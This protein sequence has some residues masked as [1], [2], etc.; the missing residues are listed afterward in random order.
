MYALTQTHIF[1]DRLQ[2]HISSDRLQFIHEADGNP[3]LHPY[4]FAFAVEA[5]YQEVKLCNIT[6]ARDAENE[7]I[8]DL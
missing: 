4:L 5:Q 6:L 2:L 7:H 8:I 3:H 1:S